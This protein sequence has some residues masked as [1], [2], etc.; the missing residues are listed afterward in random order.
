M[1]DCGSPGGGVI[2]LADLSLLNPAGGLK[3][4]SE[5]PA[6]DYL[7]W[8]RSCWESL[9]G[10]KGDTLPRFPMLRKRGFRL[11]PSTLPAVA[12]GQDHPPCT[13]DS[14]G[15]Q[16]TGGDTDGKAD[17]ETGLATRREEGGRGASMG[18]ALSGKSRGGEAMNVVDMQLMAAQEAERYHYKVRTSTAAIQKSSHAEQESF[19]DI[20]CLPNIS[21]YRERVRC[22]TS[23]L[24]YHSGRTR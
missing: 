20:H 24:R 15:D 19:S 17:R 3:S 21:L 10:S 4:P 6:E 13:R 8:R 11:Y 14:G 2:P 12:D 16:S 9:N 7:S 18:C 22:D 23:V 5:Q 1:R